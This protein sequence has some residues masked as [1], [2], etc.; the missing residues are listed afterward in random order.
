MAIVAAQVRAGLVD[1]RIEHAQSRLFVPVAVGA[2]S[3]RHACQSQQPLCS[4]GGRRA[5]DRLMIVE[6]IGSAIPQSASAASPGAPVSQ[7]GTPSAAAA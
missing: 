1:E 3:G 7:Y 4:D 2:A 6:W 5:V